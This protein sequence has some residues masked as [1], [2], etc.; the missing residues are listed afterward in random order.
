[1]STAVEL[2]NVGRLVNLIHSNEVHPENAL[3]N[4]VHTLM[5]GIVTF[6]RLWQLLN[7]EDIL[8][9]EFKLDGYVTD[10]S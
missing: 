3:T 10:L 4:D 9:Q 2:A 7:A 1:M 8:V 5:D 6:L